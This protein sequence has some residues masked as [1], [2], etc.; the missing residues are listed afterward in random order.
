MQ[1]ANSDLSTKD[2]EENLLENLN[3]E[4]D[5]TLMGLQRIC[6]TVQDLA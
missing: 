5:F 3:Y 6:K 1:N 2:T 4:D